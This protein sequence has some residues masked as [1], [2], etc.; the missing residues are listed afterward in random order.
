MEE[1]DF[2][3]MLALVMNTLQQY[4]EEALDEVPEDLTEDTTFMDAGLDSLDLLKVLCL[5][6]SLVLWCFVRLPVSQTVCLPVSQSIC[7]SDGLSRKIS[8]KLL[9]S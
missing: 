7:Q 9:P 3:N 5:H 2:E 4:L 6:L 1:E 8:R